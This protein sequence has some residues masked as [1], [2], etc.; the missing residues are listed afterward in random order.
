MARKILIILALLALGAVCGSAQ[1]TACVSGS[2]DA[3]VSLDY[4][5]GS[6]L[7]AICYAP[8]SSPS[9]ANRWSSALSNLTNIVVATNVGTVNFPATAQWWV[10][11]T[12][13]VSGSA[14][15]ALNKSYKVTAVSGTTATITTSGVSDGTY[16]DPVIV[17]TN[18]VLN[19]AVWAIQIFTYSASGI[20]GSYWASSGIAVNFGLLC[21]NYAS[22]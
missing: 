2:R 10:G 15:T 14:T 4:Y 9:N 17:T 21:S 13:T 12:I 20:T 11:M 7:V 22:Y 18:P 16:T 6:N 3:C 5:S 19:Q 1:P 8:Q